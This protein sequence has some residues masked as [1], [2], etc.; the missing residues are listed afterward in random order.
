MLQKVFVYGVLILAVLYLMRKWGVFAKSSQT[1]TATAV[2]AV[3]KDFLTALR[4]RF[5]AEKQMR[6]SQMKAGQK[7]PFWP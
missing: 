6:P 4:W 2:R 5:L 3:T 7:D 1:T